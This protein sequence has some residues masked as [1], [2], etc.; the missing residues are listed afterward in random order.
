MIRKGFKLIKLVLILLV[1]L[2]SVGFSKAPTQYCRIYLEPIKPGEIS[3]KAS[4]PV[5]F[6]I[7]PKTPDAQLNNIQP[8]AGFLIARFY[9]H[10]NYSTLLVEYF[11]D[12]ACSETVAY[13]QVSLP[14]SL[15][16]K[17]ESGRLYSNC[18]WHKVF[19]YGYTGAS[20]ECGSS[21][22]TYGALNNNVSS[23]QATYKEGW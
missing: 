18:N 16:N 13:G 2:V 7:D 20:L 1:S 6:Y 8:Q 23:W 9:D 22:G 14:P 17:F 3:S 11:G 19:D 4:D 5:C 10:Q 12:S 21:C 15:D